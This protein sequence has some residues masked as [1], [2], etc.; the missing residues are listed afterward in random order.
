M[1]GRASFRLLRLRILTRLDP[2]FRKQQSELAADLP[3]EPFQELLKTGRSE[4][5]LI[6][7]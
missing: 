5:E 4:V 2:A 6:E 7:P 3:R 1:Y